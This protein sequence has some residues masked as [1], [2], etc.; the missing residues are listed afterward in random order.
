MRLVEPKVTMLALTTIPLVGMSQTVHDLTNDEKLAES[1]F[2]RI[3]E[4]EGEAELL[5]EFAGRRCYNSFKPGIN[6]N[7]TKVREDPSEYIR[8]ILVQHHG[9]VLEHVSVSFSFEGVSRVFTAELER[10]RAGCA[11]SEQSL[12]YVRLDDIPIWIPNSVTDSELLTSEIT[13]SVVEAEARVSRM[14]N[15]ICKMNQVKDFNDLPMKIRKKYT[16]LMRRIVPMGVAT[17]L[18]WTANLRSLRHIIPL[19][20]SE[21][22][23]EEIRQ[24]FSMVGDL[25]KKH[26]PKVFQDMG[27]DRGSWYVEHE[28]I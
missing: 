13:N 2:E 20:T 3:A 14:M 23:E 18:V 21:A 28:K 26:F 9:S 5:V 27:W 10:H 24:V 8:N 6:P 7:I 1:W 11:I 25:C 17:G 15:Q 12:R 4:S 22:A 16:S 19:R